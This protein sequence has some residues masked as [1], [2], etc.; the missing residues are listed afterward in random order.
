MFGTI[1]ETLTPEVTSQV[2]LNQAFVVTVDNE[3]GFF[4]VVCLSVAKARQ[5]IAHYG[6]AVTGYS[7]NVDEAPENQTEEI[8]TYTGQATMVLINSLGF[9][10]AR[11]INLKKVKIEQKLYSNKKIISVWYTKKGKRKA[12][13]TKFTENDVAIAKGWQNV[14]GSFADGGEFTTFESGQFEAMLNQL[15]DVMYIQKH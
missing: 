13:G 11:L 7:N 15:K 6:E 3:N 1:T 9:P 12:T 8:E 5:A 4:H 10:I 2:K 14:S